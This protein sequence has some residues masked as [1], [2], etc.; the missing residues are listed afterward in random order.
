[1]TRYYDEIGPI[2]FVISSGSDILRK[3]YPVNINE[4]GDKSN[5]G[6]ETCTVL[7]YNTSFA[8]VR[9][10]CAVIVLHMTD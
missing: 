4:S 10:G 7:I 5:S 3:D 9:G 6:S 8:F 2:F 1:M